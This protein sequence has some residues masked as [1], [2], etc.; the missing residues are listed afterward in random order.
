MHDDFA[1]GFPLIADP[2]NVVARYWQV[3]DLNDDG[4]TSPASFVFDAHGSLI[5]RLIT[6]EP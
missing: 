3:F 5:A 6:N 4:K 1:L 2:L